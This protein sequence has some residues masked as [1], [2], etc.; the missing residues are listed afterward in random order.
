LKVVNDYEQ[1]YLKTFRSIKKGEITQ[2]TDFPRPREIT[3]TWDSAKFQEMFDQG[4]RHA[5][6]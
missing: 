6:A 2:M 1:A 4:M 5:M 3:A